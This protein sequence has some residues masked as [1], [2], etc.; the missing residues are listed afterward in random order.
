[1]QGFGFFR[2]TLLMQIRSKILSIMLVFFYLHVQ[3]H[4]E[5]DL[6][7]VEDCSKDCIQAPETTSTTLTPEQ[8]AKLNELL[9]EFQQTINTL[10]LNDI[11]LKL[12]QICSQEVP[13]IKFQLIMALGIPVFCII[14]A[15]ILN[16]C[17]KLI[18]NQNDPLLDDFAKLYAVFINIP[19]LM[20]LLVSRLQINM[21]ENLKHLKSSIS[22]KLSD[23]EAQAIHEI[24]NAM[25]TSLLHTK[26]PALAR[27]IRDLFIVS[28]SAFAG[29]I[30]Y[31]KSPWC[32]LIPVI[33]CSL[34]I[35]TEG[36][37]YWAVNRNE[38]ML[39]EIKE[40]LHV[41]LALS[42]D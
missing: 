34:L 8:R 23:K 22:N 18:T 24:L 15:S 4:T 1:M 11:L 38:K 39:L 10:Q 19:L 7:F 37:E 40:M 29:F 26:K 30:L 32:A 35:M 28:G 3:A 25:S 42:K 36:I 21:Y 12:K 9:L 2:G 31:S 20:E 41:R 33:V 13:H 27:I 5:N 17:K 14:L 6:R 16:D